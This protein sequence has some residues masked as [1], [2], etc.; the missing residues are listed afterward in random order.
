MDNIP[1]ARFT[2]RLTSRPREGR[3]CI[4]CPDLKPHCNTLKY[5]W[6]PLACY[7]NYS[8]MKNAVVEILGGFVQEYQISFI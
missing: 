7:A 8:N 5:D 6:M 1:S 3:L 4:D 2:T